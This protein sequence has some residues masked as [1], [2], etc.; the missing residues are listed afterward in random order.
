MSA[1][2]FTMDRLSAKEISFFKRQEY[3]IKKGMLDPELMR[4]ARHRSWGKLSGIRARL[5]RLLNLPPVLISRLSIALLSILVY[6][7]I[8]VWVKL[9]E[10]P[11][12]GS[13]I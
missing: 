8:T 6:S 7:P 13:K 9:L 3:L 2:F 12:V 1:S 4:R 5:V 11:V 10:V